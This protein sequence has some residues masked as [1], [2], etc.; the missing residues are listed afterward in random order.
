MQQYYA[1]LERVPLT[2]RFGSGDASVW[3]ETLV[4]QAGDT[5]V[6]M[7]YGGSNRWLAGKPAIITR[8]VREGSITDIGAWLDPPLMRT[9]L[10][11][12]ARSA[13]VHP[14]IPAVAR[15]VEVC[16]RTGDGKRV[17]IL[18]NHG[19]TAHTVRLPAPATPLLRGGAALREVTLAPH[20]VRVLLGS[21]A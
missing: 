12:L 5:Q 16:E 19:G 14:L 20:E 1:L 7:R 17:W 10:D 4:A 18:I 13:D 9:V 8:R 21:H 11:A 3:A 6:L 2:G 15:N